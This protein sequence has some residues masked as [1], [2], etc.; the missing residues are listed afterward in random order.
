[1]V[2]FMEARFVSANKASKFWSAVF[3][4][5]NNCRIGRTTSQAWE[6]KINDVWRK[7]QTVSPITT[8]EEAIAP[9]PAGITSGAS[10]ITVSHIQI[11]YTV[12]RRNATIDVESFS[13]ENEL[14]TLRREVWGEMK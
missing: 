13:N 1:M 11:I 7:R 3:S 4:I 8:V 10:M 6:Q 2:S 12:I 9:L 5:A 14:S